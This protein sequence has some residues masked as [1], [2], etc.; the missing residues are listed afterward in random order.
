MRGLAVE[1]V[2]EI[3]GR[4]SAE[5]GFALAIVGSRKQEEKSR[6]EG[7]NDACVQFPFQSFVQATYNTSIR[8]SKASTLRRAAATGLAPDSA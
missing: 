6:N 2:G 3:F 1:C 4:M 8:E 5:A 7:E